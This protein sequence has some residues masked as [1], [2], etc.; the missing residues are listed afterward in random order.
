[1][2]EA[3]L[4]Y[5]A[6]TIEDVLARRMRTLFLDANAAI[7]EAESVSQI[8][9][10]VLGWDEDRRTKELAEFLEKAGQYVLSWE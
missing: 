6:R 1:V 7:A 5:Y 2:R 3:V 8:M 4:Q 10:E 9:A